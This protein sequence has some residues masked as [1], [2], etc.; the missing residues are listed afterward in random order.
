MGIGSCAYSVT[1][2]QFCVHLILAKEEKS[3]NKKEEPSQSQMEEGTEEE[4]GKQTGSDPSEPEGRKKAQYSGGLVLEPKKGRS[5][6]SSRAVCS[7][8]FV[9]STK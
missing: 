3:K 1:P 2:I 9:G 8:V 5:S 7:L 4:D 6:L